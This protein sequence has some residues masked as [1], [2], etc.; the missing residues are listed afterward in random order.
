MA[1]QP[2]PERDNIKFDDGTAVYRQALLDEQR[3]AVEVDDEEPE[4]DDEL[5]LAD[6]ALGASLA[7]GFGQT[8]AEEI[9]EARPL[10][11]E[12]GEADAGLPPRVDE[13][14][15][16][17]DDLGRDRIRDGSAQQAQAEYGAWAALTPTGD[18]Q[19]EGGSELQGPMP[20]TGQQF[21]AM[22]RAS[23]AEIRAEFD[24]TPEEYLAALAR[25]SAPEWRRIAN[26]SG[27]PFEAKP[28]YREIGPG[29]QIALLK[30]DLE[31]DMKRTKARGGH[32]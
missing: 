21:A 31:E 2:E 16:S 9:A 10:E 19:A 14:W 30:A 8:T 24:M 3:A 28:S 18:D 23:A 22:A 25:A 6:F 32:W 15:A 7:M 26:A 29:G 4:E 27:I 11:D 1:G 20:Q 5:S 13:W 17:L 12:D